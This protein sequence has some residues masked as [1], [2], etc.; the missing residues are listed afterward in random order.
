MKVFFCFRAKS[1]DIL[2]FFFFLPNTSTHTDAAEVTS[3]VSERV[4]SLQCE[5]EK[6]NLIQQ[7]FRLWLMA[8]P[9]KEH[10]FPPCII[11]S[12]TV[13]HCKLFSVLSRQ[14]RGAIHFLHVF[15]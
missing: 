8:S 3:T 9:T 15:L 5:E 1:C 12:C 4:N 7:P 13:A 14:F 6:P 11:V 10:Q 2:L